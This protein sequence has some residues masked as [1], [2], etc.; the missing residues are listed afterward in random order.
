MLI[1]FHRI[2]KHYLRCLLS[3]L[4]NE[5]RLRTFDKLVWVL[6]NWTFR[7]LFFVSFCFLCLNLN[8]IQVNQFNGLII[9]A[10]CL[11]TLYIFFLFIFI[12]LLRH[13]LNIMWNVIYTR[14]VSGLN[15]SEF[16][17]Q[18]RLISLTALCILLP[19]S[20]CSNFIHWQCIIFLWFSNKF[21]LNLNLSL[22]VCVFNNICSFI[23]F[24]FVFRLCC[25]FWF[26]LVVISF[27]LIDQWFKM[28]PRLF[29]WRPCCLML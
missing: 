15:W 29:N 27:L 13:I 18:R 14:A 28:H 21:I 23:W 4:V 12:W 20:I 3:A 26:F 9:L 19:Y 22:T 10:D 7:L 5:K 11:Q 25:L 8:W 17:N 1:I 16:R 2:F 6:F 24:K